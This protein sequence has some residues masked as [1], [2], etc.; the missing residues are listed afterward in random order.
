MWD[1]AGQ[2][3]NKRE[4]GFFFWEVLKGIIDKGHFGLLCWLQG[5]SLDFPLQSGQLWEVFLLTSFLL[6]GGWSSPSRQV[7]WTEPIKVWKEF[8]VP[9]LE[10]PL[11]WTDLS[12]HPGLARSWTSVGWLPNASAPSSSC[13]LRL[14]V[15]ANLI[16]LLGG[17]HMQFPESF[18]MELLPFLWPVTVEAG[19]RIN[20]LPTHPVYC[21]HRSHMR[22]ERTLKVA[23]CEHALEFLMWLSSNEPD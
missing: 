13:L 8:K 14:G 6:P 1:S 7:F 2:N 16:M 15:P 4:W 21:T 12:S 3:P 17:L 19:S 9:W 23:L 22:A 18:K 20:P 11:G 5:L 10:H